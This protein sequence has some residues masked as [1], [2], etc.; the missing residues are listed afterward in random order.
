M[1]RLLICGLGSLLRLV[2]DSV[3]TPYVMASQS[4]PSGAG[5]SDSNASDEPRRG[6]SG[7]LIGLIL[8]GALAGV[9]G[10]ALWALNQL[11]SQ[12]PTPQETAVPTT[13]P[14]APATPASVPVVPEPVPTPAEPEAA[15][16]ESEAAPEEPEAVPEEPEAAPAEPEAAPKT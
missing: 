5:S 15:P 10:V 2:A 8:I 12:A 13:A 14:Q 9:A 1:K 7:A 11:A 3:R 6:L 4:P 16:E